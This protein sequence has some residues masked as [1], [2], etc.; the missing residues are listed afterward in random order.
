MS[1]IEKYN[2][3]EKDL[4]TICSYESLK[5]NSSF[6]EK[7]KLKGKIMG[8]LKP[9]KVKFMDLGLLLE[10]ITSKNY[11]KDQALID[12]YGIIDPEKGNFSLGISWKTFIAIFI[13]SFIVFF[14]LFGGL[15]GVL[16]SELV[17]LIEY[18]LNN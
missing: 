8:V 15:D 5:S 18:L 6:F 17:I 1:L 14:I 11:D 7:E 13:V 16:F 3:D 10:E 2:I 12:K 4:Y 9:Y